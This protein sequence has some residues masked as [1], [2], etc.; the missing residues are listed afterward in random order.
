MHVAER[1]V[2]GLVFR[3]EKLLVSARD[4]RG[5]AHDDPVLGAVVVHLQL[6]L[7]PGFTT[8]R[9]TWKRSPFSMRS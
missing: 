1:N 5:T 9:L 2:G 7:R 6:R 8:M 3:R 4:Q